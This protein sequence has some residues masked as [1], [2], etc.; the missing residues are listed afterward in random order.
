MEKTKDQ[1]VIEKLRKVSRKLHGGHR[2]MGPYCGRGFGPGM[3][4]AGCHGKGMGPGF[5]PGMAPMGG[6]GC[7]GKGM[8]PGF[9]PGMGPMG[10]HGHRMFPRERVLVTLLYADENGLR[11][12]DLAA[13]LGIHAPALTEQI[14]RLE[15]DRYL[16]RVANP[17]D[18][19]STL[20]RLTEKGRARAFE[21]ADERAERA[22]AVCAALTD[23][24]KDAL[25]ALLDKLLAEPDETPEI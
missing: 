3:G 20:I 16:E 2:G 17:D 18:R 6:H 15:A 9:G 24:E 23:E 14:D 19:R 11:Q 13:E 22:A 5:G 21:V 25:I 8:G 10:G 7:H 1:I 4:P 12:K